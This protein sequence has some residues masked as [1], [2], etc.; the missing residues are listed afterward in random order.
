MPA[1]KLVRRGTI[2]T[3]T[4]RTPPKKSVTVKRTGKRGGTT[5]TRKR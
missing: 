2:K 1:R 4:K 3:T 5:Q